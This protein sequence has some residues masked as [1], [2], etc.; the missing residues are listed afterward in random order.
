MIRNKGKPLAPSTFAKY[1]SAIAAIHQGFPDGST[2]SSNTDR[3]REESQ[4]TSV[5]LNSAVPVIERCE[6]ADAELG[7]PLRICI[8]TDGPSPESIVEAEASTDGQDPVG[9]PFL[10]QPAVVPAV[11]FHVD[12]SSAGDLPE[13]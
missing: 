9:V 10:A 5:P 4:T 11:D 13:G 12:G 8:S 7:V 2:V 6:R 1:R 3:V